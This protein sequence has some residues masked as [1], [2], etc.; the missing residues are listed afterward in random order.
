VINVSEPQIIA[1]YAD[2]T[3]FKEEESHEEARSKEIFINCVI[4]DSDK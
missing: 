3:D 2:F 4:C 1:D